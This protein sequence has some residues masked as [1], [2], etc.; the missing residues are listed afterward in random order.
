M[1]PLIPLFATSGDISSGFQIQSGQPY[2]HLVEAYM[3]HVHGGGIHD[4]C[5]LRFTSGATPADLLMAS[6][7]ASC[8]SPHGCSSRGRMPS[9][10]GRPPI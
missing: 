7:V 2:S 8:C 5:S 3:M 10:N 9:S 1:G 4:A 6:M